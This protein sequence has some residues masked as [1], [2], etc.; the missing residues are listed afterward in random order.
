VHSIYERATLK[1]W[2][3]AVVG[4]GGRERMGSGNVNCDDCGSMGREQRGRR[5]QGNPHLLALSAPS[6]LVTKDS[7][8]APHMHLGLWY[9]LFCMVQLKTNPF[10]RTQREWI[11]R[12]G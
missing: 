1:G 7:I 6:D 3:P 11:L 8:P 10:F 12:S 4:L 2:G 5:E 9:F